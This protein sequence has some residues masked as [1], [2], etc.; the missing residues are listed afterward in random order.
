MNPSHEIFSTKKKMKIQSILK[1]NFLSANQIFFLAL[2][3]CLKIK[4]ESDF[5]K[6]MTRIF[7]LGIDTI[8]NPH[9][10]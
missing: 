8:H 9:K 1:M 2:G 4:K 7:E 10:Y 5:E 3:Y 6:K